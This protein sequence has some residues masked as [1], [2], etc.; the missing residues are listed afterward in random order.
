MKAEEHEG[1]ELDRCEQC[2][3]LFFDAGE[4]QT[5]LQRLAGARVDDSPAVDYAE[6][7][8]KQATCPRCQVEMVPK[9]G[10]RTDLHLDSCPQ[11]NAIFLDRGELG[12][13]QLW[14]TLTG[15]LS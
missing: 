1:I 11:C 6:A 3:G 14:A 12:T 15:K 5:I 4:L 13:L 8:Q 2:G 7:D 10:P 9:E